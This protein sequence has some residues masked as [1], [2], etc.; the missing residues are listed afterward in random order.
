M[1]SRPTQVPEESFM[2]T[3]KA[4]KV[5]FVIGCLLVA[6]ACSSQ[7]DDSQSPG[8]SPGTTGV[9]A[10]EGARLITGDGGDPI[11]NSV[12]IV[13]NDHFTAVGRQGELEV[14]AGAARV[15]LT[16]KTVMPAKVDMHGHLGFENVIEGTTSGENFTR[17]NLIDHLKRFAYMGYS[18]AVSIADRVEREVMPG[19]TWDA[20]QKEGR[21]DADQKRRQMLGAELAG[22]RAGVPPVGSRWPWGD[23]PLRVRDEVL[24]NAALFRTAGP[25]ISWPGAGAQGHASRNVI[26]YGVTTVEEARRAVQDYVKMNPHFIK[27]WLDDRQRQMPEPTLRKLTPPLYEAIIDEARKHGVYVAAHTVTLEDAKGLYRAGLVGSVHAPVR[28][29]NPMYGD[30]ELAGH[31]P[32]ADRERRRFSRSGS[33]SPEWGSAIPPEAFNDPL[34]SELLSPD[35]VERLR[36]S[37]KNRTPES[38]ARAREEGRRKSD[39]ARRLIDAGMLLVFGSDNGSAGRGLRLDGADE[40]GELG[41]RGE[42][43]ANGSHRHVDQQRGARRQAERRPGRARQQRRFH[44]PRCQPARGHRQHPV[45]QPRLPAGRRGGPRGDESEVA[46]PVA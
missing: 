27:I 33:W 22:K 36:E 13:E 18:A 21:L 42:L 1:Q 35:Q 8:Q 6:G 29:D 17:E 32:G 43:L 26:P 10:F 2:K 3:I 19:D 40:G 11:E 38:L 31:H 9:T 37:V 41:H 30:E 25:A 45:Y 4:T 7:V 16:G 34:L 28:D 24:P 46:I 44:R 14:P 15:D 20:F 12:F 39:E 5:L 23:V